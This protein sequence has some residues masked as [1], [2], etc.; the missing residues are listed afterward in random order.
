ML[1]YP[2]NGRMPNQLQRNAKTTFIA[3]TIDG[4]RLSAVNMEWVMMKA[5]WILAYGPASCQWAL[6]GK[7]QQQIMEVQEEVPVS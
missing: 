6:P 1:L 2:E 7:N 3:V 5:I 4:G